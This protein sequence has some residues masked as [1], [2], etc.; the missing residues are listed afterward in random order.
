MPITF[1]AVLARRHKESLAY[2][3]IA[4]FGS[5]IPVLEKFAEITDP[6]KGETFRLEH[7]EVQVVRDLTI[8]EDL[9]FPDPALVK[10]EAEKKAL[11]AALATRSQAE[12]AKDLARKARD[13]AQAAAGAVRD[14]DDAQVRLLAE[15]DA[16]QAKAAAAQ[17]PA[18]LEKARADSLRAAELSRIQAGDQ[19]TAQAAAAQAETAKASLAKAVFESAKRGLESAS[20]ADLALAAANYRVDIEG[21]PKDQAIAKILAASG[22]ADPAAPAPAAEPEEK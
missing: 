13:A 4:S 14:L 20:S 19:Q 5:E 2:A 1:H 10:A 3:V 6:V 9:H 18:Q 17:T 12:K 16:A 22:H 21:L 15:Y 8:V 11:A 7:A